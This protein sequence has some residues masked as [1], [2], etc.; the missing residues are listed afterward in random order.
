MLSMQS[1]LLLLHCN[2]SSSLSIKTMMK[3][4]III[5]RVKS[6]ASEAISNSLAN[7]VFEVATLAKALKRSESL[8][9]TQISNH[10]PDQGKNKSVSVYRATLTLRRGSLQMEKKKDVEGMK[11]TSF[12]SVVT[13]SVTLFNRVQ[14]LFVG[15]WPFSRRYC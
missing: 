7:F 9:P 12:S 15:Q 4:I 6:N 11:A 1:E 10:Q 8:R 5:T 2:R 3:T 14:Q 13:S